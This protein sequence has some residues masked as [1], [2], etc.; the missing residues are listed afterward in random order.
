[1]N[2]DLARLLEIPLKKVTIPRYWKIA[3][4]VPIYKGGYRSL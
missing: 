4:V 2:P 1:M 3:T